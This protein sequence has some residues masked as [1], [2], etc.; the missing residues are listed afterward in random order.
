MK[1]FLMFVAALFIPDCL[2]AHTTT[3]IPHA[4]EDGSNSVKIVHFNPYA[5]ANIMGIRLGE[6]DTESLKGL[7]SIFVIHKGKKRDFKEI[8]IPDFYTVRDVKRETYSI[9]IN[10]EN[11]FAKAGDYIIVVKHLPHWKKQLGYYKQKLTK[12]FI[13]Y[14]GFIT[15]W[16]K[17]VLDNEPEIIPLT[18]PYGVYSGTLFRAEAVNDKGEKIPH[19]EILIEYLNYTMGSTALDTDN[20]FLVNEY[21]GNITIFADS[22]GTFSFI[23][24]NEGVWT[25][26]LVDGDD[27]K[28]IDGKVLS[29]DSSVSIMVQSSHLP[30]P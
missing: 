23:P 25:F 27:N 24:P 29:Y 28:T 18:P 11:G 3:L 7:D 17:R 14:G 10:R 2:M 21:L 19:A 8:V 1:T 13:N 4:M 20:P 26:T 6:Q 12:S 22:N 15:D 30:R 9:P 16:P 5:G